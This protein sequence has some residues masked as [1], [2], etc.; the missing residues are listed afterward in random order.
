MLKREIE[1]KTFDGKDDS[2]VEYFNLTKT[3]LIELEVEYN[4]GLEKAIK[5]IIAT[6]DRKALITEFKRI[7]LLSYGQKSEDGKRFVKSETISNDFMQTAAFDALFIELATD[8]DKA[9]DFIQGILPADMT[10][11]GTPILP[12]PNLQPAENIER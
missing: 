10:I 2:T 7:I 8:A 6:E 11:D 3:E 1:Y 4:D 5:R 12:P 9:A